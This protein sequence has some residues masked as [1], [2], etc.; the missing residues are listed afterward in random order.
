MD[1]AG[2]VLRLGGDVEG[3]CGSH[4]VAACIWEPGIW[5]K[6]EK[7][8]V[9]RKSLLR[10]GSDLASPLE[11]KSNLEG[12]PRSTMLG[13]GGS[14]LWELI[15]RHPKPSLGSWSCV[16]ELCK[17]FPMSLALHAPP[18][19]QQ[20]LDLPAKWGLEWSTMISNGWEGLDH[21]R[22]TWRE[23]EWE[24]RDLESS[25]TPTEEVGGD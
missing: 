11:H 10:S 2:S 25:G 20:G 23:P 14:W 24:Q 15:L 13:L 5:R 4:Q 19:Y 21:S 9:E 16:Q 17:G 8:A 1:L 22:R 3:L 18:V 6:N 7:V 12:S